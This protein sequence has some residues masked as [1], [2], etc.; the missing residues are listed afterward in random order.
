[1]TRQEF[2]LHKWSKDDK[3]I[4]HTWWGDKK[5]SVLAVDFENY[6]VLVITAITGFK[7]WVFCNEFDIVI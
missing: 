5:R 3:I 2:D 7:F 1:M 4:T 6:K